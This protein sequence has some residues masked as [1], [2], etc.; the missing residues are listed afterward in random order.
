MAIEEIKDAELD[1]IAGGAGDAYSNYV[2]KDGDTL[3][4]IAQRFNTT[5]QFIYNLNRDKISNP[6]KIYPGMLIKV[7]RI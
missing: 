5:W 4:S 2:I 1:E 7:P 3:W 6:D